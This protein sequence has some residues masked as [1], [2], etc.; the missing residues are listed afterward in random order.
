MEERK[1]SWLLKVTVTVLF[2]F[3]LVPV[4]VIVPLSFSGENTLRFPPDSW[5]FRW[6]GELWSND[7]MWGAFRTSLVIGAVVTVL[8]ILIALPAAYVI[9]RLKVRGSELLYNLF[10]AP[11]LLPTIVIGL[12]ILIIFASVGLLGTRLGIALGH[13]VLTLPYALRILATALNALAVTVEEAAASLG[14]KPLT[15]FRRITLPLIAPGLVSAGALSF[16][17]S[18][19]EVVVT[20][21]LAGPEATTLPVEMFR[22]LESR[23]DPLIAAISVLLIS[24]TLAVVLIVHRSIGFSTSFTR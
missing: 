13:L 23:S 24:L 5:S 14:A 1:P 19:D 3:L 4:L 11:L 18:F 9:V 16:L 22:H 20:L 10:T 12:A 7:R 6:Y 17:V 2:V 21:F 15:V 8:T